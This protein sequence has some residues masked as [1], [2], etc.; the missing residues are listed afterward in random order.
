MKKKLRQEHKTERKEKK[1]NNKI[2]KKQIKSL[3]REIRK[4]KIIDLLAK[5]RLWKKQGYYG[6]AKLETELKR[7]KSQKD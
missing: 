4:K 1:A 7:L 3:K 6:T 2:R 5:L